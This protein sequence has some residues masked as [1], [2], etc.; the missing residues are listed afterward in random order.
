MTEIEAI[1]EEFVEDRKKMLENE[2]YI[3]S[4][5]ENDNICGLIEKSQNGKLILQNNAI[6]EVMYTILEY[7]PSRDLAEYNCYTGKFSE[8]TTRFIMS[9]IISILKFVHEKGFAHLDKNLITLY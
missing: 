8:N 1:K 9:K 6:I 3:L 2:S 5:L 4:I 7:I